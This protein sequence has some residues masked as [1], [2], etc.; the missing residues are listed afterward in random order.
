MVLCES[1]I[2]D[3][4]QQVTGSTTVSYGGVPIELAPP[5]RRVTM[6]SLVQEKIGAQR[7]HRR[8]SCSLWAGSCVLAC[9]RAS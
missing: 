4:S 7:C 8:R 6:A 5:W 9:V 3:V 1:M 2:S